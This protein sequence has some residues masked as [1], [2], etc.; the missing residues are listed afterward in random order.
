MHPRRCEP[1][2][3]PRRGSEVFSG[4]D[5]ATLMK[6]RELRNVGVGLAFDDFETG[7]AALSYLTRYPLTRIKIDRSFVAKIIDQSEGTDTAIVRGILIMAHNLGLEVAA[8]G[9]ETQ[10]QAEYLR[11]KKCEEA[12]GYLYGKPMPLKEFEELLSATR[13]PTNRTQ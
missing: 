10:C 7:Y 9:V 6:L 2:I 1:R 11:A 4:R 12:Q 3:I 13:Q 5:E 8:E